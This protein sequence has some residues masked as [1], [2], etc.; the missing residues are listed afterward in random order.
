[1]RWRFV[2]SP[3]LES[4]QHLVGITEKDKDQKRKLDED[5]RQGLD[6]CSR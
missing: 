3:F 4:Q 6:V 2:S 1:M 5:N